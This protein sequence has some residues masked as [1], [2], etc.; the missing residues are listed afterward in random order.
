MVCWHCDLLLLAHLGCWHCEVLLLI[1]GIF[2]GVLGPLVVCL[3]WHKRSI[4]QLLSQPWLLLGPCL[5]QQRQEHWLKRQGL[6]LR[7][8]L[9]WLLLGWL[10]WLL[11]GLALGWLLLGW[12]LGEPPGAHG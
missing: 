8:P 2:G 11:L 9:G 7:L 3:L 10:Q 4:W 1:F 6:L 5:A 12:L